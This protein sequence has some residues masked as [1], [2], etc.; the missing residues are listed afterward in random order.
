MQPTIIQEG[1]E[2][3]KT[4]YVLDKIWQFRLLCFSLNSE[5]QIC[6]GNNGQKLYLKEYSCFNTQYM[7]NPTIVYLVKKEYGWNI[8]IYGL[9]MMVKSRLEK[10]FLN[11]LQIV[12][13]TYRYCFKRWI[14]VFTHQSKHFM[15][16]S[17]SICHEKKFESR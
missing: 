16:K 7:L 2:G 14:P 1:S 12:K 17:L 13:S 10:M 11:F 3:E 8:S 4:P 9:K 5:S 15:N 6:G